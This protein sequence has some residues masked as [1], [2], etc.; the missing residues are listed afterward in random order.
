MQRQESQHSVSHGDP[1]QNTN[2]LARPALRVAISL[3][4]P[5]SR[6]LTLRRKMSLVHTVAAGA[7]GIGAPRELVNHHAL[8]DVGLVASGF[9][10][11]S[12]PM[13]I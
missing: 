5:S 10:L 8:E 9:T 2:P 4:D 13:P 6:N 11:A 3:Q 12:A 1:D 7:A